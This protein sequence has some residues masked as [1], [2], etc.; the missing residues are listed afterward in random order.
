MIFTNKRVSA[1]SYGFLDD[2][3]GLTFQTTLRRA[4]TNSSSIIQVATWNDYGEG[5][6]SLSRQ[7]NKFV[8]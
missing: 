4:M 8:S 6:W 7:R 3:N 1:L 2:N 5:N